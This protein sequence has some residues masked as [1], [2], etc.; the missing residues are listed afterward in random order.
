[1]DYPAP[2]R[3]PSAPPKRAP[4]SVVTAVIG[5]R[6]GANRLFWRL[7]WGQVS[8]STKIRPQMAGSKDHTYISQDNILKSAVESMMTDEQQQ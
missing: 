5:V 6:I 3:G 1:V 8:R 7:R 4:P 2:G